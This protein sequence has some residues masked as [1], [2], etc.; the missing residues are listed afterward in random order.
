MAIDLAGSPVAGEQQVTVFVR[1]AFVME[2][3]RPTTRAPS[4][5]RQWWHRFFGEVLVE[6]RIT[7]VRG[8]QDVRE[9]N[10][11]PAAVIGIVSGED[12]HV[13]IN[14]DIEDVPLSPGEDLHLRS[15]RANPYDPTTAARECRSIFGDCF[16]KPK[17]THGNVDPTVNPHAD[18]VGR[19]ISSALVD[20]VGA[21]A[22]DEDFAL[23]GSP[24]TICVA[25]DR[26]KR[27]VQHP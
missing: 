17:V 11:P 22:L 8:L 15:V 13:G 18:A 21:D 19:V 12:V 9:T 23:V 2:V 26:Q 14:G 16:H 7:I 4:V 3:H 10:V 27:R 24:V 6:R 20:F 25:I 5:V 1:P